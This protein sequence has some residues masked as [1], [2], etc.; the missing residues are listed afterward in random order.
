MVVVVVAAGD[1]KRW[2]WWSEKSWWSTCGMELGNRV[3]AWWRGRSADGSH[4]QVKKDLPKP[5]EDG[6]WCVRVTH[7]PFGEWNVSTRQPKI[8]INTATLKSEVSVQ[9]QAIIKELVRL[10]QNIETCRTV[11]RSL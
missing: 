8:I 2:W 5:A 7:P 4:G 3:V 9:E 10:Q 6:P 11:T 1:G